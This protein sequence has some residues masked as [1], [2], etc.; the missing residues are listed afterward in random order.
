MIQ[1]TH[2]EI[3][4]LI[5][6]PSISGWGM[7]WQQCNNMIFVGLSDSFEAYYQAVRRCWRFG[8]TKEVNVHIVISNQEGAVR[9]N[10]MRKQKLAEKMTKSLVMHTKEILKKDIQSSYRHQDQYKAEK[11]MIIPTWIKEIKYEC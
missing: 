4:T 9:D 7:N 11:K 10:L 2:S 5:S 3:K 1:F 6:K 8:Q